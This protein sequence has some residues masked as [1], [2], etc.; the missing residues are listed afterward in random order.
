M[1]DAW[2]H[3]YLFGLSK[4]FKLSESIQLSNHCFFFR[5]LSKKLYLDK[6]LLVFFQFRSFEV[7]CRKKDVAGNHWKRR[8]DFCPMMQSRFVDERQI[9]WIV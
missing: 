9:D 4:N 2:I 8:Y 3:K 6:F 1:F 5:L 7:T